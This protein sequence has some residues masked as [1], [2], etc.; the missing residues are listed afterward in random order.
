MFE[1]PFDYHWFLRIAIASVFLYHGAGKSDIGGFGEKF[2]LP[3]SVAA[4][5]VFAELAAGI[6]Y[7]LGGLNNSLYYGFTI[8]QWASIA[9]IPVLIG[10]ISM[11]HWENGFNFMKNGYEFQMVLLLIAIYFIFQK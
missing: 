1:L 8:T 4:L 11:V 9:A 2:N 10:A 6:G 5:V 3:Y 7:L